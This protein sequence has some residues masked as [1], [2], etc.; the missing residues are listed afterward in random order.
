MMNDSQNRLKN[1]SS[2]MD[3]INHSLSDIKNILNEEL[4][5]RESLKKQV[6]EDD[7]FSHNTENLMIQ[8]NL[9]KRTHKI[10]KSCD[11]NELEKIRY[12]LGITEES[13]INSRNRIKVKVM[14]KLYMTTI[15]ENEEKNNDY[16]SYDHSDCSSI[17]ENVVIH[18]PKGGKIFSNKFT[19][20]IE[21]KENKKPNRKENLFSLAKSI[22]NNTEKTTIENDFLERFSSREKN[23][24]IVY[25]SNQG[26][27]VKK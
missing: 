3:I 4:E 19:K 2:L 6:L 12:E 21:K 14:D 23:T 22:T 13:R 24:N 8:N 9:H 17:Q 1:Y 11:E 26:Y 16:Y 27:I 7:M 20:I 25:D 18:Q 15:D 5:K 10:I